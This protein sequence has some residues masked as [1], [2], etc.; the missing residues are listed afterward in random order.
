[1]AAA[2]IHGAMRLSFLLLALFLPVSALAGPT[3]WLIGDSTVR[4]NTRGQKGWGEFLSA[5]V[6]EVKARVENAALGGRSSRSF[7]RE[8]LWEKVRMKL[9]PG[10]FVVMQF[11]HND[12]GPIDREKARASLKGSGSET[13]E[14][15]VQETGVKET[16]LTH[17]GYLRRYMAEAKASGATPIVCSLI[18]RNIW[19]E[20]KV[21]RAAQDYGLWAKEAAMAEGAAFVPLNELVANCYDE[22]GEE[23]VKGYFFGDHTHTSEWGARLNAAVVASALRS[24]PAVAPL[25]KPQKLIALTFD[26]ACLSHRTVV[27]PRLQAL[28]FGA[29]FFICEYPG[30]F[31]QA[32]QAMTWPQI[33]EVHEMGFEIGNHTLTH[34]HAPTAKSEEWAAELRSIDDRCAA[35]GLPKPVSF[36]WPAYKNTPAALDMVRANGLKYARIGGGRAYD[37]AAD[38]ALLIPS[39]STSGADDAA[40]RRVL[41]AIERCDDQHPVILTFHGVPDVGHPHVSTPPEKFEKYLAALKRSGA[42]VVS[43]RDLMLRLRGR[44]KP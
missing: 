40:E 2:A 3:I 44:R 10:D 24:L 15:T 20:G 6:D 35:Q 18:P 23:Q 28:G 29:T 1:M 36:A 7:L 43:L 27:A 11:G 30:M 12:G 42:E 8:G 25:M 32:E 31:G 34:R 4:N 14:V 16:V 26:D 19:K 39:V 9:Q 38:D 13:K 37:P 22:L 5:Q 41:G 33:R 17:G 21:V